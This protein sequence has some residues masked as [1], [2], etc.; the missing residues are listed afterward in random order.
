M[1]AAMEQRTPR[2]RSAYDAFDHGTAAGGS[3]SRKARVS[4]AIF[5]IAVK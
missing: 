3:A 1:A 2:T 5:E 4:P